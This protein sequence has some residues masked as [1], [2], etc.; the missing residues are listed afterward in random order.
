[1]SVR[2]TLRQLMIVIA[3]SA[4]YFAAMTFGIAGEYMYLVVFSYAVTLAGAGV[5]LYNV[6]LSGWMWV[7]LAGYVGPVLIGILMNVAGDDALLA[8]R[9]RARDGAP[10]PE[11]RLLAGL[12]RGPRLDIP[13]HHAAT[14]EPRSRDRRARRSAAPRAGRSDDAGRKPWI[15]DMKIRL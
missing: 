6:R 13:G 4:V 2:F 9:P 5:L 10:R 15:D 12:H 11:R 1:M 14:D 3:V 8:R 7:A